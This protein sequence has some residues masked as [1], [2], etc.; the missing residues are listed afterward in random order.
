MRN[1]LGV[2]G[3]PLGHSLSPEIQNG[4]IK[5]LGLDLI[6]EKWPL[7]E[8]DLKEFIAS[9]KMENSSVLGFNVTIPY[10]EIILSYLDHITDRA[11][12]IGAVNT[13]CLREGQLVGENTD[14]L[15]FIESF[16]RQGMTIANKNVLMIGTGGAAKG[17]SISLALSGLKT[18]DFGGRNREVGSYLVDKIKAFSTASQWY[19]FSELATLS[20]FKYDFI[21]QTTPLGIKGIK[22]N[23]EF[24][25]DHLRKNQVLVDIIYNPLKTEF[26]LEGE[27]RGNPIVN[28]V[29]MLVCQGAEALTLWTGKKPNKDLM[30]AILIDHLVEAKNE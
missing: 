9:V 16:K 27:K 23:L 7:P 30:E 1:R 4:A 22:G 25:Y 28:G 14:G 6:Y 12:A 5:E 2:I 17:I 19:S 15:G 26:L 21:I 10:K 20:L 8:G 3:Y 24:P 18:I 29:G 13:V 11:K